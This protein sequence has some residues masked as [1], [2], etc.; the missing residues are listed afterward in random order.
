V[1]APMPMLVPVRARSFSAPLLGVFK[2]GLLDAVAYRGETLVWMLSTTMPIV[3]FL[4]W[5][6]AASG[7]SAD[8]MGGFDQ[9]AFKAYFLAAFLVRQLAGSWVAFQLNMEIKDGTLALRLLR[10][11]PPLVHYLVE[12]LAHIPIRAAFVFP[13]VLTVFALDTS[14]HAPSWLALLV[15]FPLSIVLGFLLSF[16][17]NILFGSLAFKMEQ[18]LKVI[19][20]WAALMF[21]F[22]GYMIPQ[23]LFPL[24]AQAILIYL[25]F[26]YQM[27]VPVEILT[28]AL[29]GMR[30][31]EA[32]GMQALMVL[33]VAS[34]AALVFRRGLHH[35]EAYGG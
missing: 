7:Q 33:V 5:G 23:A 31:V 27:G 17:I 13:V 25:P 34:L 21:A 4:L 24:W 8:S 12:Q 18:S 14:I 9:N 29:T 10:P 16:F 3:M 11:M 6:T 15:F 1:T 20:I 32:L 35:F 30:L 19:D 22:S 2:I 26:R 28:G